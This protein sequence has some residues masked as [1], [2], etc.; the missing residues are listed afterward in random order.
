MLYLHDEVSIFKSGTSG[1]LR[2]TS[3]SD[4]VLDTYRAEIF[5]FLNDCKS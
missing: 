4:P 5:Q 3:L 2:E 1:F